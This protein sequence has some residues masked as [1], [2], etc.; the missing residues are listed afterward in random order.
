MAAPSMLRANAQEAEEATLLREGAS[1]QI[2][3]VREGNVILVP[4]DRI[5]RALGGTVEKTTEGFALE[6]DGRRASVSTTSR[7]ALSGEDLITM[8]VLPVS[9]ENRLFVPIEFFADFLRPSEL[10][11]AWDET[12]RA[13]SIQPLV[14]NPVSVEVSIIRVEP[15]SKLILQTESKRNYQVVRRPAS[16]V[17]RFGAPVFADFSEKRFDDPMVSRVTV[18]GNELEIFLRTPQAAA[19]AYELES[20]PRIILDI[21]RGSAPTFT[22]PPPPRR[23][24]YDQTPELDMIVIDPGHGGVEIG[25]QAPDGFFEKD[26]TLAISKRLREI[27]RGRG[28][29]VTLTR[30]EDT[31]VAHDDRTAIANQQRADLFLSIH[32]NAAP[33]RSATGAETYFL[34]LKATDERAQLSAERENLGAPAQA[35]PGGNDL[36]L[37]LWD[38]AQQSY[39]K[40]SSRFA[41]HIQDAMAIATGVER[42]GVKQ[43]PFRVLVGA[44]MPAVLVEVGFISNPDEANRLRDDGYQIEVASALADGIE[45]YRAEYASRENPRQAER[46]TSPDAALAGPGGT[47]RK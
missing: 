24:S 35:T 13:V 12:L 23:P 36:D 21:A 20:P 17:I 47:S 9:I 25:A 16:Y 39:L 14:R 27:L 5:V 26:L 46:Q 28:W 6:V 45:A 22:A 4:A 42:R 18:R 40:E 41:E 30:D 7:T 34:S 11:L 38:L 44:M 1:E 37:I 10:A 15:I 33:V 2:L 43:A 29:R 19:D 3:I 8:P 31:Q 32:M